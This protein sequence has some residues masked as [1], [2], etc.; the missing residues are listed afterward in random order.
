[1]LE[2]LFGVAVCLDFENIWPVPEG[3]LLGIL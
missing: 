2:A 1:M 3:I